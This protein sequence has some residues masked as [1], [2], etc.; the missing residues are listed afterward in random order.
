M[1]VIRTFG[2]SDYVKTIFRRTCVRV[3]RPVR[4]S[5]Q[6]TE[7]GTRPEAIEPQNAPTKPSQDP[8]P[9]TKAAREPT[10]ARAQPAQDL[11]TA[12]PLKEATPLATA[13]DLEGTVCDKPGHGVASRAV[14]CLQQKMLVV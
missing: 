1:S 10:K 5:Q 9:E 13:A 3:T 7:A 8:P 11:H 12:A 4:L 6:A 14:A 2:A